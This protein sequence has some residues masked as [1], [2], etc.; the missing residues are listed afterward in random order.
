MWLLLWG[1]AA[2]AILALVVVGIIWLVHHLSS[3]GSRQAPAPDSAQETL[4][5]RYAAGEID[6]DEFFR[7]QSGLS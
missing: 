5:R 6:E 7:R 2:I 1:L 4:R 3:S